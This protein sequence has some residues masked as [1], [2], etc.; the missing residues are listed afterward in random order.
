MKRSDTSGLRGPTISTVFNPEGE[1]WFAV[2]VMVEEKR[3]L[4]AVARLREIGGGSVRVS[5]PHYLFQSECKSY[6]RL[7]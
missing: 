6:A 7:I 4:P 5:K 2:T 3:L 1:K